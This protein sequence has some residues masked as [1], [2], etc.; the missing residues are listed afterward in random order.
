MRLWSGSY[1]TRGDRWNL[2]EAKK[3]G[4]SSEKCRGVFGFDKLRTGIRRVSWQQ[5][6]LSVTLP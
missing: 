6:V 4:F 5:G 2:E 1:F 3:S